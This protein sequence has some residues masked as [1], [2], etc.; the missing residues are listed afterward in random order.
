[1]RI[2][3]RSKCVEVAGFASTFVFQWNIGMGVDDCTIK[4]E[5]A[6]GWKL[7]IPLGQP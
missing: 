2:P 4:G 1:M 5:G 6:A 7:R 3:E